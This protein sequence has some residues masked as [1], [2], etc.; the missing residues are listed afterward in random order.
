MAAIFE[1]G[2]LLTKACLNCIDEIFLMYDRNHDAWMDVSEAETWKAA[3]R[4]G[5]VALRDSELIRVFDGCVDRRW[6][7]VTAVGGVSLGDFRDLHREFGFHSSGRGAQALSQIFL[8]H[9]YDAD[10]QFRG[11]RSLQGAGEPAGLYK[12]STH[13]VAERI[14]VCR[15]ARH[16]NNYGIGKVA[17]L[18]GTSGELVNKVHVG[19]LGADAQGLPSLQSDAGV[20]DEL[21]LGAYSMDHDGCVYDLQVASV[22]SSP[23]VFATASSTG[24]VFSFMPDA[25]GVYQQRSIFKH[26]LSASAVAWGHASDVLAS[27]SDDGTIQLYDPRG[28]FK[29]KSSCA[30]HGC[31]ARES[32]H[33]HAIQWHP[34]GVNELLVATASGCLRLYDQRCMMRPQGTLLEA[35]SP[36]LSLCTDSEHFACGTS[37][38]KL[39]CARLDSPS[40]SL[41]QAT[42]GR[43]V[44][45]WSVAM[46]G[47][48]QMFFS[49]GADGKLMQHG[50]RRWKLA[51]TYNLSINSLDLQQES[52]ILVA[53]SDA[54]SIQFFCLE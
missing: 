41:V 16:T 20:S 27:A 39:F 43:D 6:Q 50:D 23:P 54:E 40:Q 42:H 45:V 10:L 38:G 8:Q 28:D 7:R 25:D 49:A 26:E 3:S 2:G 36:L 11:S 19:W 35:R 22:T 47:G 18:V 21:P 5:F 34:Q 51:D 1:S 52:D 46:R 17:V 12:T 48:A 44:P 4:E 53:G 29:V 33:V 37:D 15:L 31:F 30:V 13:E 14:S 32:T 24:D 9:G